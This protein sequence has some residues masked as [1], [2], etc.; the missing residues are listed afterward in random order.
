V[1]WQ[2][3]DKNSSTWMNTVKQI[4]SWNPALPKQDNIPGSAKA[5]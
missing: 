2:L 4:P 5:K 1:I 3:T